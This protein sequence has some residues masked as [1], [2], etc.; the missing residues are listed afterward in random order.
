M[1]VDE[2]V[3]NTLKEAMSYTNNNYDIKWFDKDMIE[4]YI[5]E[6][7]ILEIIEDLCYLVDKWQYKFE[8]LKSDLADN[9]RPVSKA[10]QYEISDRD[11]YG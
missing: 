5:E 7:E 2:S 9:Y 10:E 4:G 6:D 11:F 1:K 3:Y 8:D